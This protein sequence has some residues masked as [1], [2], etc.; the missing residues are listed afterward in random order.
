M[1]EV[2]DIQLVSAVQAGDASAYGELFER[3]QSRIYNFSYG[4]LGSSEDAR[5][6]TQDAF[7]RV[8]EAIPRKQE[9]EFSAY[10]YRVARNA[11]YDVAKARGRFTDPE[12]LEALTEPGVLADPER[13]TTGNSASP[14][15]A[16]WRFCPRST[17][18][19]SCS[20]RS[21]SSVTKR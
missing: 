4:I 11:S 7:L 14:S 10:L 1:R 16:P 21:R 15:R 3:Y 2:T 20:A 17:A 18:R 9:L 13:S 19:S 12:P 8:F 6:V 5:D